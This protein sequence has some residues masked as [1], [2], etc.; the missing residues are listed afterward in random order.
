MS[1][2]KE[3]KRNW[4]EY[5]ARCTHKEIIAFLS[6]MFLCVGHFVSNNIV[7]TKIQ[8]IFVFEMLVSNVS[9]QTYIHTH[10]MHFVLHEIE[11]CASCVCAYVSF[12]LF[13]FIQTHFYFQK[14]NHFNNLETGDQDVNLSHVL[15]GYTSWI[16]YFYYSFISPS[17]LFFTTFQK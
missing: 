15:L 7:Q 6:N 12:L 5:V 4:F 16:F 9:K 1:F 13:P 2:G 17:L 11:L 8:V 10:E 3:K 14:K